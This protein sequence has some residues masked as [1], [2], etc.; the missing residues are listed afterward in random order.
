MPNFAYPIAARKWNLLNTTI[1]TK[2]IRETITHSLTSLSHNDFQDTAHSTKRSLNHPASDNY[3]ITYQEGDS[4]VISQSN[5]WKYVK[6]TKQ[7]K[8]HHDNQL[9]LY[10]AFHTAVSST[11]SQSDNV[12]ENYKD[13]RATPDVADWMKACDAEMGK[14]RSL[15]CWKVLPRSSFSQNASV[16]KK[17]MD[18]QIQDQRTGGSQISQVSIEIRSQR[19]S[20][21]PRSTQLWELRSSSFLHHDTSTLCTHKYSQLQSAAK[22]RICRFHSRETWFEPSTYLMWICR[23]IPRL[24]QIRLSPSSG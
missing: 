9:A 13:A 14:L 17:S 18:I 16:M 20:W 2:N 7:Y 12:P 22:R 10:N 3:S 1:P 5:D 24:T 11:M 4:E 15:G 6:G 21:S 23:R 8:D 19:P